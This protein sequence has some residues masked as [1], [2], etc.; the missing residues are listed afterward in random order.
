MSYGIYVGRDLTLDGNAWLAGYGDE[1]SSHWLE[2]TP[3]KKN[4][5]GKK[6][7]HIGPAKDKSFFDTLFSTSGTYGFSLTPL[8]K[9]DFIV[10]TGLFNDQTETP[11]NYRS[12]FTR[13]KAQKL[14]MICTNP[15]VFVDFG[16]K[17]LFCAG[18]LAL[19]YKEIGGQVYSFGKPFD[20]IY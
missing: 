15:D 17:R 19:S 2:I 5:L 12:I 18:A 7:Y 1:P 3:S 9:A 11:E 16:E 14:S 4:K 20:E 10:C 8:Q 6:I 13:A